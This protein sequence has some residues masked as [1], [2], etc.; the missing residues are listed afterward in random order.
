MKD[1]NYNIRIS[2][3]LEKDATEKV[4]ALAIL[5]QHL[6]VKE[7]TKLAYVVKSDPLKLALAKKYLGV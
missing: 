4:A 7:L 1:Y 5:A 3:L 6:N 2:A